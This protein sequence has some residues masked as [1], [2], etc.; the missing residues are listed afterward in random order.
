MVG[1]RH[2]E[3][4]STGDIISFMVN[5]SPTQ[6]TRRQLAHSDDRRKLSWVS[7]SCASNTCCWRSW[8]GITGGHQQ[9]WRQVY[10]EY[11][12]R[13]LHFWRVDYLASGHV[14]QL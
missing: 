4:P 2:V 6:S 3:L 11:S 14:G 8:K 5:S 12:A 10:L 1:L 7:T 9:I 13:W